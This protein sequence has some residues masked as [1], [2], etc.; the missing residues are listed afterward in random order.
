V[1]IIHRL[2]YSSQMKT[3]TQARGFTLV[4]LLVAIA[5]FAVLSALG[6][7]VFDHLM[8]VKDRNAYH[9]ENLGQLQEAYLQFQRDA[10][11]IVPISANIEGQLQPAL[12]LNNQRFVMSKSGV[13]D[14]LQQGISPFER[15]EYQYDAQEK[16]LYR[17]KYAN[18][19]V[20]RTQQPVSS[21]I[22]TD[23]EQ[24]QVSVLNPQELLQW[25]ENAQTTEEAQTM[26]Q[27]PRGIKIKFTLN[28]V[29]YEWW[30]SL[31]DT[32][33]MQNQIP[34]TPNTGT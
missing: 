15:V 3:Q 31:L 4:E 22:L 13:S 19:N 29:E 24:F 25:P 26:Q 16:K 17:L 28:E 6:W 27:L 34:A 5:I 12:L 10:L 20:S 14:P 18:I 23:I 7:K 21:V 33:F 2:K 8:K 30:F 11:Q 9:E 1:K 32:R